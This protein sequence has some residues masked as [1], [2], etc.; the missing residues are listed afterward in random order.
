MVENK[1]VKGK[2]KSM[3]GRLF[4]YMKP[5]VGRYVVAILL[6]IIM[7]G[8]D[9]VSPYL[10]SLSLKELGRATIDFNKVVFYFIIGLASVIVLNGVSYVQTLLL[11]YTGQKIIFRIREEVF[12]H[13]QTFSHHQFNDIPVGTLVTRA[14]SDINV[15]F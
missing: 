9:L 8:C 10:I 1:Q 11:H 7:V 6:M 12:S 5:Y 3:Y 13:I 4:R 15:L 14:T 2:K